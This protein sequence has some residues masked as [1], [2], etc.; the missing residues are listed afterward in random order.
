MLRHFTSPRQNDWDEY[1]SVCEFAFNNNVSSST[2]YSPFYL[3]CGQ[4]PI[5]PS[6][7][8][9]QVD[10][11]NDITNQTTIDMLEKVQQDF[12]RAAD[13]IRH[14]QQRQ[15]HYANKKRRDLSFEVGDK[16]LLSGSHI[17]QP[18]SRKLNPKYLGPFEITRVISPVSYQL[19][20]PD[21]W[22]IHDVFHISLLKPYYED[23][24]DRDINVRPA[25]VSIEDGYPVYEVEM[26][27]DKR[28]RKYGRGKRIEYLVKWLGYPTYESTWEPAAHVEHLPELIKKYEDEQKSKSSHQ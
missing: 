18:G 16:V 24:Y 22:K 11:T 17:N 2:G 21:D 14:A 26:I 12:A 3:Y 8:T 19:K 27:L 6:V 15:S 9:A 23:K 10:L 20:L 5:S 28:E 4:H 13:N 7:I 1:L 25:A